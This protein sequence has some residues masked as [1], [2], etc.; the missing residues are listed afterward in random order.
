MD[1]AKKI[2]IHQSR[3]CAICE[4]SVNFKDINIDH[5]HKSGVVRG[6]LC[7]KCNLGFGQFCDNK[8]VLERAIEY[9]EED[10][11]YE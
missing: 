2:W 11:S 3:R 7:S 9:L 8:H 10:R 6:I 1:D 5:N 4:K